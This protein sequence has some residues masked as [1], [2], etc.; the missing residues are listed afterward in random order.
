MGLPDFKV[1]GVATARPENAK[2]TA[3]RFGIEHAF[4]SPRAL[5]DSPE[6]DIVTVCVRVPYHKELVMAALAAGKHVFCEWPLG[7]DAGEARLMLDAAEAAGVV[8]MIGLQGRAAP[9]VRHVKRLVEDGAIGRVLALGATHSNAWIARPT[10]H[11][12]Y[13]Q[14]RHSGAHLLSIPGGHTLD[15][16]CWML[17]EF[18]YVEAEVA[19]TRPNLT[20][21]ETGEPVTR[22]SADQVVVAGRLKGGAIAGV[23]LTAASPPG[24][25]LRVEIDGEEGIILITAPPRSPG[26]WMGDLEAFKVAP[27]G[28]LQKI[29]IPEDCYIMPPELRRNPVLNVG[30]LYPDMAR[31]IHEGR[32]ATPNFADA[33]KLHRLL[34]QIEVSAEAGQR[35]PVHG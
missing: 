25:G 4:E 35:V 16:L 13:V 30:E 31:A 27:D 3:E 17:G 22:T 20:M 33:L 21:A 24:A 15:T 8:H 6:I 32:D 11:N 5:I 7:R 9:A 2:A 10:P 18:E 26:L 29:E 28:A 34:D 19:T 1:A 12:V 14:D 23:R